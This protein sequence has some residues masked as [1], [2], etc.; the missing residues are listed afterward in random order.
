M[1]ELRP[2]NLGEMEIPVPGYDR[3]ALV[4]GIVHFGVGAFHRAHQAFFLN[5]VLAAGSGEWGIVGV[6]LLPGDQAVRDAAVAQS[7]LYTL[8]TVAPDGAE[9]TC[10]IGSLLDVCYAPEDPD[11][12]LDLL[13]AA[14]TR[15][16]SLTVTEGGYP[17]DDAT[18]RFAPS[19]SLVLADLEG[20]AVPQS[21]WGYLTEALRRRRAAGLSPFT[22]M[23]CDN[24]Q[25][26]GRVAREA[27]TAFA[28]H[29]SPELAD[30]I[31]AHV[32]FP[33]SMVDRITPVVPPT[34]AADVAESTQVIDRWPVRSE[35][36]IQW[37]LED[38]FSSGRPPLADVGVSL[39]PDVE[40]YEHLKL[41]LLNASHQVMSYLGL[42]A[43]YRQV[44]EVCQDPLFRAFLLRY[45]RSEAIPTL[46]PV[47]GVD[48]EA[49][50]DQL[51][52]RFSSRAIRDTLARQVVDASDRLPKFLLPVLRHQ[53]RVGGPI[54]CCA[55]T[56]AAW[57][58]YLEG[59]LAEDAPPL[60]DRRAPEL[61][62]VVARETDEPGALLRY[63]PVFGDL[64]EHERLRRAWLSARGLLAEA[65]AAGAVGVL[66]GPDPG[67]RPEGGG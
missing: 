35:A 22:V 46:A 21:V 45:M 48:P 39:V 33:S 26:N 65:G 12:V 49:Y 62:A 8:T 11:R 57:A 13:T 66:M 61:L 9:T 63:A 30:W 19:D 28:R 47:P 54:E 18:G 29:Q 52:A 44:D 23:S 41:R 51:I 10:V 17:I 60:T 20:A 3:V 25:S 1:L 15:I 36:F 32:D 50:G 24:I 42:L 34:L 43:G 64:G 55:L 16:V 7:G 5:R 40:P 38:R 53:L 58:T 59:H 27:L 4:P 37:V 31:V 56:L 14:T 6:G 67:A 2:E